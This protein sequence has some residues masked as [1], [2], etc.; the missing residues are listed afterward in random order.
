VKL[1]AVNSPVVRYVC[2]AVL[3]ACQTQVSEIRTRV[4][5]EF[6]QRTEQDGFEGMKLLKDSWTQDDNIETCMNRIFFLPGHN[7]GSDVLSP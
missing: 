7:S 5:S 4:I 6:V 3:I 2:I 1:Q